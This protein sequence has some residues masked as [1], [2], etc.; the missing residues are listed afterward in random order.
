MSHFLDQLCKFLM[1]LQFAFLR[2]FTFLIIVSTSMPLAAKAQEQKW[3]AETFSLLS[4]LIDEQRMIPVSNEN[5]LD[6]EIPGGFV[7]LIVSL[8]VTV[9]NVEIIPRH[10]SVM[11]SY[12]AV[13]EGN[14]IPVTCYRMLTHEKYD[15]RI[16]ARVYDRQ[17]GLGIP[18]D[19]QKSTGPLQ[20]DHAKELQ[21]VIENVE[22]VGT[23][24]R[25]WSRTPNHE[26]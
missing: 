4:N 12:Q 10:T 15:F 13:R 26:N 16:S 8:P 18:A 1:P 21:L 2:I 22:A 7:K 11:C 23:V 19:R 24:G 17:G 20:A 25:L 3:V 14:R 5:A 9:Q 6:T